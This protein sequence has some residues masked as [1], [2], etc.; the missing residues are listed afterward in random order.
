MPEG[1]DIQDLIIDRIDAVEKQVNHRIEDLNANVTLRLD[2]QDK[3][4]KSI[5]TQTTA[6]NGRVTDHDKRLNVIELARE[7]AQGVVLAY[8]WVPAF[9]LAFLTAGLT[10]LVSIVVGGHV[11]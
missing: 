9:V 4:L 8:R 6:T 3:T 2:Q 1:R 5:E 11:G 7:R 10:V